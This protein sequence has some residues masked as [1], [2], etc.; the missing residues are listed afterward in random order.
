V[1]CT[2][3]CCISARRRAL[4]LTAGPCDGMLRRD[5]SCE[6]TLSLSRLGPRSKLGCHLGMLCNLSPPP[7]ETRRNR[8]DAQLSDCLSTQWCLKL[9]DDEGV[10]L[11]QGTMARAARLLVRGLAQRLLSAAGSASMGAEEAEAQL[12]PAN[13]TPED[14]RRGTEP[15]A[16]NGWDAGGEETVAWKSQV[17]SYEESSSCARPRTSRCCCHRRK[18]ARKREQRGSQRLQTRA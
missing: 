4:A 2:G 11:L 8:V 15:A 10:P 5:F 1:G 12:P 13:K 14:S 9:L 3:A 16:D 17:S 6:S 18:S 7:T